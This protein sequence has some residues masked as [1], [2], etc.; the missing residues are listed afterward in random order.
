MQLICPYVFA[1][2]KGR[3]SHD[4]AHLTVIIFKVIFILTNEWIKKRPKNVGNIN[5]LQNCDNIDFQIL[6][7]Y[8]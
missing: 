3:F 1:Y 2:S 5:V 4:T 6:N 7:Y 8:M